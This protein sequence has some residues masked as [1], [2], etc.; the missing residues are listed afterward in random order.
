MKEFHSGKISLHDMARIAEDGKLH[1]GFTAND[2][3]R[4]EWERVFG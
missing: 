1:A 2:P 3:L 4:A